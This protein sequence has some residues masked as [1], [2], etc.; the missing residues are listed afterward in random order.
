MDYLSATFWL[1]AVGLLC[2]AVL[3][4]NRQGVPGT[5]RHVAAFLLAHAEAW[6]AHR[7]ARQAGLLAW[8]ER[9][10]L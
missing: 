7:T 2:G 5:L 10:G 8:R 4:V 6:E 1:L 9:F 3:V